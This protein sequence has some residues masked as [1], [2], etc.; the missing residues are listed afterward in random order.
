MQSDKQ[1]K[2]RKARNKDKEIQAL[3]LP[4]FS[5]LDP[6]TLEGWIALFFCGYLLTCIVLMLRIKTPAT[7]LAFIEQSS[8]G[9]K[10]VL[11]LGGMAFFAMVRYFFRQEKILYMS[12]S[13]LLMLCGLLLIWESPKNIYFTIGVMTIVSI[14]YVFVHYKS[15]L[16]AIRWNLKP[17]MAWIILG[18]ASFAVMLIIAAATIY[19]HKTFGTSAFDF[20]IFAHMYE[21][22]RTIGL[23]T[24]TIERN[25]LLSHFAVH[26]SPIFYVLLPGYFVFSTPEYLL[27][28]QAILIASVGVPVFLLARRFE[29]EIKNALAIAIGSIMLPALVAPTFF[30][31]H[32]NK[33]ITVL[34][35]WMFYFY[36]TKSYKR[37]ALFF[38]LV[39]MV[40]E[41]APIYLAIFGFYIAFAKR[42]WRLGG[43][44]CGISVLLFFGISY[45]MSIWGEGVMDHRFSNFHLSGQ[46]GLV[47][48]LINILSNPMFFIASLFNDKKF[49]YLYYLLAPLL[50]L[51]FF[52]KDWKRMLLLLP[53]VLNIMSSYP[54]LSEIG[55]QYTYAIAAF[56]IYLSLINLAD[57]HKKWQDIAAVLIVSLSIAFTFTAVGDNFTM[58]FK[59]YEENE[60]KIVATKNALSLIPMGTS[61]GTDTYFA[62]QLY[63]QKELYLNPAP[64]DTDYVIY[65]LRRDPAELEGLMKET[66]QKG[67]NI[68][69]EAGYIR[70]YQKN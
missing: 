8:I 34:L 3:D 7:D 61:I 57:L 42:Q 31:F 50:F 69:L 17:Y 44:I 23:Q 56:L 52:T 15:D 63:R 37:M 49:I 26:F 11:F 38:V 59:I 47:R 67:Y 33:F 2:T 51:P 40:K 55:F 62:P 30:D 64:M 66:E 18:V 20:G 60:Q 39:L 68:F 22:M 10:G 12:I 9:L 35:L 5:K 65:D 54:Y 28:M 46:K 70:I 48:V 16:I 58:F 4:N 21:S 53:L 41:D 36:E 27:V 45:G 19:R 13:G 6:L 43:A 29:L 25:K 32:E 24:T 1:N 14:V